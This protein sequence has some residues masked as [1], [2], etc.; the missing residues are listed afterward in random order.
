MIVGMDLYKDSSDKK[1]SAFAFV[2]S[3]N[4]E[5]HNCSRYYSRVVLQERKASYADCL[6]ILMQGKQTKILLN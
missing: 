4:G 6:K 1:Q 2:A 3:M 5:N